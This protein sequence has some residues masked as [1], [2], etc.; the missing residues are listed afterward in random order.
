MADLPMPETLDPE[1]WDGLRGLAHRIVDEAID[2]V[3]HVR[4]RPVWQPLP[5]EVAARLRTP[6]PLEP[7]GAEAVYRD[8]REQVMPYSMGNI[9]PRFWAWYMGNGTMLGALGEFL[10]A[11]LNPNVGGGNH[12]ANHIE[13]QVIDW[14]KQMLGY[15]AEASGLL[16]SGGS[17]ANLV[18]LTVAR[19]VKAGVDVRTQGLQG[20]AGRLVLYGSAEVHSCNQKAVELLGLGSNALRK[21]AVNERYEMDIGALERRIAADRASGFLP[22]CVIGTAGTVNT[23]AIDDLP[24]L[25]ELCRREQLWFHVD[26]AIGAVVKLAPRHRDLVDGMERADSIALDPHKWLHVPFEAGCALVRDAREH[27]RSFALTPE[28]LE[29]TERGL[30]SG[31]IWFSEYGV[32]LSRGFRALKVWLSIKEHGIRKF[33]RLIEQNIAQARYLAER[34]DAEAALERLAPAPL[35]IVCFR[36]NPGGLTDAGL[37]ALNQELLV[38]LHESGVAAPSYTTLGGKYCLRAAIVNHR[39][40][41]EDLDLLI[42]AV[43][44]LGRELLEERSAQAGT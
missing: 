13:S 3:Q 9:H 27:R 8:F 33:G 32:Q 14:C 7:Q 43:C 17:M 29:H 4:E 30:A 12:V 42:E 6:V 18:G 11:T 37:S 22:F 44:R 35:N 38:R 2:F 23:G 10:A 24:A 21:I 36:Y 19:N 34:I 41:T 28:Y 16:V 25:A 26:G 5:A 39:T 31:S 1:D 15:P 20:P 40:R